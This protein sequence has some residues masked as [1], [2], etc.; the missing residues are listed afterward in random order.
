[1]STYICHRRIQNTSNIENFMKIINGLQPL[2]IS[3]K[4]SMLDALH[5][6][7]DVFVCHRFMFRFDNRLGG[8]DFTIERLFSK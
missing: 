2:T 7:E 1:M 6:S 5:G 3:T 8:A 4:S